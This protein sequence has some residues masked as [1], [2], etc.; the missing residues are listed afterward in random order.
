MDDRLRMNNDVDLLRRNVK[1]PSCLDHFQPFIHQ[2]R[3]IDRDPFSHPPC[4]MLQSLLRRDISELLDRCFT[5]RP[6]GRREK[7]FLHALL[8]RS[9]QALK[10]RRML[11]VDG[12]HGR[13]APHGRRPRPREGLETVVGP[14]RHPAP[15]AEGLQ[16]GRSVGGVSGKARELQQVRVEHG[17]P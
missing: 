7:Q 15:A 6:S 17:N 16:R 3:R 5:E 8:G 10:E 4:G 14:Q 11:T 12:Q 13:V 9:L 2:R 1:K